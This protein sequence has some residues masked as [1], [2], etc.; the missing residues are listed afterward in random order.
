MKRKYLLTSFFLLGIFSCEKEQNRQ[1]LD[2]YFK[3]TID[4][5]ETVIKDGA[6][7]NDNT[8]SCRI[9]GDTL[10]VVEVSKLYELVGFIIKADSIQNGTYVLNGENKAYYTNPK[11]YKRYYTT[12]NF[13]GTLTIQKKIFEAKSILN[14]VQGQFNFQGVDTLTGKT[15]TLSNGAFLMERQE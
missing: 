15:F 5:T 12:S 10:L 6:G 7:L 9:Q 2:A 3:F 4:G 11:D 14:T 13:G 8:F 1:L